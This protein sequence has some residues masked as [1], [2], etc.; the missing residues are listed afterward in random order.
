MK[1]VKWG[2]NS[3]LLCESST[4]YV[5]NIEIYIGKTDGLFVPEI[6]ATGSVI[7]RLAGCVEIRTIRFSWTGFIIHHI[8]VGISY[9][10]RYIVVARRQQAERNFLKR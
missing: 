1:P 5:Y 10:R 7:A 9:R 6:C 3:F 4:E 2:I 8:C